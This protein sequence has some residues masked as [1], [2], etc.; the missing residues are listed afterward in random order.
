[1]H[2]KDKL[3]SA[4]HEHGGRIRSW[5]SSKTD[6]ESA[7]DILQD[8]F[9]RAFSNIDAMEPIRDIASWL[10]RMA[11]NALRDKWRRTRVRRAHNADPG[12]E[13]DEIMAAWGYD[14]SDNLV[15]AEI[16]SALKASIRSLPHEQRMVIEAQC[17][18]GESFRSISVRTGIPIDTLASR[19]RYALA[20]IKSAMQDYF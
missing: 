18:S 8:V 9:T 7:K 20:K 12:M 19:K 13:I 16:L 3:E 14:Q 11:A 15:K 1:M 5:L 6:G 4:Y 17:L 10:W 2:Q